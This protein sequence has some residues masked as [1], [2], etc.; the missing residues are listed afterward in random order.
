MAKKN[1][2]VRNFIRNN[3][4]EIVKAIGW[5]QSHEG[6]SGSEKLDIAAT[7]INERVDIGYVPEWLEQMI[8]KT[9][10]TTIVEVARSIWGDKDW[11]D[12]LVRALDLEE[13]ASS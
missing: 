9:A 10:L 8:F 4:T 2:K 12:Q 1:T 7:W 3:L 6:I 13:L 11:F 5:A